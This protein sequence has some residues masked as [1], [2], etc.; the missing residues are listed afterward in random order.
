VARAHYLCS[1]LDQLSSDPWGS[2]LSGSIGDAPLSG[3]LSLSC[4]GIDSFLSLLVCNNVLSQY[5]LNDDS[6]RSIEYRPHPVLWYVKTQT[7]TTERVPVRME[8]LLRVYV[9]VRDNAWAA[10]WMCCQVTHPVPVH[11]QGST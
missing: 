9:A 1:I 7:A 4:C 3:N 6:I 5:L 10:V 8:W 2:P 11:G